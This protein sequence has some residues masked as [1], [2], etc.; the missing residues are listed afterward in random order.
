MIQPPGSSVTPS[1]AM[2]TRPAADTVV[3]TVSR[4]IGGAGRE[5]GWG[6]VAAVRAPATAARPRRWDGT[7]RG[8]AGGRESCW[9]TALAARSNGRAGSATSTGL[10]QGLYIAKTAPLISAARTPLFYV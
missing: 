4:I 7:V 8:S 9:R 10:P 1:G 2:W 6:R 5:L 3:T